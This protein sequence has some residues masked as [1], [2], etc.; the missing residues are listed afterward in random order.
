MSVDRGFLVSLLLCLLG[1][2]VALA[3][4][5][6]P[7]FQV[8]DR[9]RHPQIASDASGSFVVVWQFSNYGGP[10][11]GRR[12]DSDG[13]P[14]GDEFRVDTYTGLP[15]RQRVPRVASDA[16]GNVIVVWESDHKGLFDVYGQQ[17]DSA[18]NPLGGN[19]QV[20]TYTSSLQGSPAVASDASGNFVVVWDSVQ[21]GFQ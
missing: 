6:G 21:Y 4:P 5:V 16:S 19:F 10:I 1:A 20:N 18:G 15:G 9:G 3:Q 11:F 14:L 2:A 12:Y 17:Y 7:E 13:N 8:T